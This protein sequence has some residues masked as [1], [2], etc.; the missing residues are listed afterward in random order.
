MVKA[1]RNSTKQQNYPHFKTEA[2]TLISLMLPEN[3]LHFPLVVIDATLKLSGTKFKVPI[4]AK[5]KDVYVNPIHTI[6][7]YGIYYDIVDR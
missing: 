6:L 4:A 3:E 1:L 5:C 7:K 2:A